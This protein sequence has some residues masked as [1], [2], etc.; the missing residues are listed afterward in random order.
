VTLE[1]FDAPDSWNYGICPDIAHCLYSFTF[2]LPD[3]STHSVTIDLRD[4]DYCGTRPPYVGDIDLYIRWDDDANKFE[5]SNYYTTGYEDLSSPTS[6]WELFEIS[7]P[8]QE[9]FQP[10]KPLNFRCTNSDQLGEHPHFAWD[11]TSWPNGIR[12]ERTIT[13][14][15]IIFRNLRRVETDIMALE[16]TDNSV[17]IGQ[18]GT[19]FYYQAA[20]KLSHSPESE[21]TKIIE[22]TGYLSKQENQEPFESIEKNNNSHEFKSTYVVCYPN[23]LNPITNISYSLPNEGF[24]YIA[25]YNITGQRVAELVNGWRHTGIYQVS[26]NGNSL[27]GGIY[28]VHFKFNN[29]HLI[30]KILLIK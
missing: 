17:T 10:T 14:H 27:A 29:Q 12:G 28:F 7:E 11:G 13:V 21:R 23:P 18:Q 15:Y 22:I 2:K 16:W 20:A 19:S 25:I 24:V 4:S 5:Y 26:L 30:R 8:Y 9:A 6:I 3:N 1:G